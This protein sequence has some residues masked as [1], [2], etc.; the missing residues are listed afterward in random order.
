MLARHSAGLAA[1]LLL[2]AVLGLASPAAATAAGPAGAD[3]HGETPRQRDQRMAW[4][5]EG[6]VGMFVHWGLFSI[7]AGQWKGQRVGGP[8]EWVQFAARI[9]PC[10]YEPLVQQ[11][12][13]TAFDAHR[14]ADLARRAGMKYLVVTAKHHDGFCLF[15]SKLTG[16][17]VMNAPCKRD[18]LKELSQACRD[19]GIKIG[20]HYSILDWRHPDYLPRGRGSPRP[21]DDRTTSGVSFN[22]YLDD[23]EGQ[24]GELLTNYGP[25]GLVWFDG[26]WEHSPQELRADEMVRRVRSW[27]PQVIV[28]DRLGLAEDFLTPE[29]PTPAVWPGPDASPPQPPYG[30]WETCLTINNSR[31]FRKDDQEWKSSE[32]LLR[33]LIDIVSRGGNCL[34]AVGPT[35]EGEI[36]QPVVERLEAIGRWLSVNGESIYGTTAGPFH[37]PSWGRSTKKAGKLYLHLFNWQGDLPL[38]GLKNKVTKAYL[39]TDKNRAGVTAVQDAGRTTIRLPGGPTDPIATVVVV[40]IEGDPQVVESPAK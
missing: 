38:P 40:E 1:A 5:R 22:R 3:A 33:T 35:A 7:P 30:D 31:G 19:Q 34:L 11:F 4:W 15:D 24:L 8:G 23:V 21:W 29:P 39:L 28:N 16:Y 36:P 2:A 12:N 27:Q 9:P 14:W 20:W 18:L 13:P 17:Q 37:S 25:I 26:G 6:R 10:E 32:V